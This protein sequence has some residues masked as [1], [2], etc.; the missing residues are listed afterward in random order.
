MQR[1]DR[2]DRWRVSCIGEVEVQGG[3]KP[4]GMVVCV[5]VVVLGGMGEQWWCLTR[6]N[7]RFN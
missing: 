1:L 2:F 3:T 4:P 6:V 5:E 7:A